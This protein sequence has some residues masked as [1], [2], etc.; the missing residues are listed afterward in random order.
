MSEL[1]TKNV[2]ELS[3]P[4]S[5][6]G[7]Q[8]D[9]GETFLGKIGQKFKDDAIISTGNGFKIQIDQSSAGYTGISVIP[10][11]QVQIDVLKIDPT[12]SNQAV[13]EPKSDS[14][15][16][17]LVSADWGNLGKD[18]G[19]ILWEQKDLGNQGIRAGFIRVTRNGET[20]YYGVGAKFSGS[21]D[22]WDVKTK[23][24]EVELVP[25][26]LEQPKE[27]LTSN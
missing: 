17:A 19:N 1:I 14:R 13:W 16:R 18:A 3:K 27:E 24:V 11:D 25:P 23:M 5:V 26:K 7:T 6:N 4:M 8:R 21:P 12:N 15:Q 10:D 22:K 9:F 20:N 2:T